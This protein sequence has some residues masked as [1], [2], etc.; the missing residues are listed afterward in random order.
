[1]VIA[2]QLPLLYPSEIRCVFDAGEWTA[3]VE[4]PFRS[5]RR[6][7][8]TMR[9]SRQHSKTKPDTN[10]RG[11]TA[12]AILISIPLILLNI[13]WIQQMEWWWYTAH[14]TAMSIFFSA[15][16]TL[17]VLT[18][19]NKLLQYLLPTWALH[20][21]E[22]LL[23]Y[24]MVSIGSAMASHD[25]ISVLLPQMSWSFWAAS[26]ENNWASLFNKDLPKW[27]TVQDHRVL[28]GFYEGNSSLYRPEVL[29]AWAGPVLMWSLFALLLV[30]S[31]LCLSILIRKRWLEDEHLSCPLT[32]VPM[33]IS[34]P[35]SNVFSNKL[36]WIGFSVSMLIIAWNSLAFHVPSVPMIPI[37]GHKWSGTN[38][39]RYFTTPPWN[40]VGWMPVAFFPFIIGLSYLMPTDF[41][42]SCWFFY[43][44][45]KAEA[46][47]GA[48][49]G[50]RLSGFPFSGFQA[51]GA[52]LL[53]AV[54]SLWLA[55]HYIV[56]LFQMA[57]ASARD[58]YKRQ[59]A[60]LPRLALVVLLLSATGLLLFSVAIGMR[61]WV[62]IVFFI[63][64]FALAIGL[65][66]MRAQFGVPVHD[67][68]GSMPQNILIAAFG[69]RFF[70]KGD[71]IS[72]TMYHWF[73]RVYRS[74]PMP[75]QLEAMQMQQ[76]TGGT[77]TGTLA[78]LTIA[79]VV[80]IVAG[81][82]CLLHVYYNRGAQPSPTG[83]AWWGKEVYVP[84]G[85]WINAPQ[86]PQWASVPSVLAGFS[87][88]FV[89]QM[90][91]MRYINW[92]L[93]PLGYAM[94]GGYDIAWFWMP[95]LIAW[96]VK[97]TVIRY[98]GH[99]AYQRSVPIFLGLLIGDFF[100]GSLLNIISI[101]VKAVP[102]YMF[103]Y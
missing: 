50:V 39:G 26:V 9:I 14:P 36:F 66:R 53:F 93:H 37:M 8:A 2:G 63:L 46:V 28:E 60:T 57:T 42:F 76:R 94:S 73:N 69:S 34:L 48:Y 27:L 54:Y 43:L 61:L 35:S 7:K 3:C 79:T 1:L 13:Y 17:L 10:S 49:A 21:S 72:F 99:K 41:L 82:W 81:F 6:R 80:G 78:P 52:Y 68:Y 4:E 47:L 58:L 74:H 86:G 24:S 65:S 33:E 96:L 103:M 91:R 62:A 56:Q 19:V 88:A 51:A 101:A 75:H 59:Q 70:S 87:F 12:K 25:F 40:A 67:L 20:R 89:L 71:L 18:A 90:L 38:I 31:M 100:T 95:M 84:L 64:Y 83:I 5:R 29:S 45:W 55:R 23:I 92:P 85:T 44:F 77:T 11:L 102:T 22:L 30:L 97:S 98:G 15:V 16:F 32:A